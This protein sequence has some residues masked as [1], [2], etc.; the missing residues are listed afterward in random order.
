[1]TEQKKDKA[2]KE[3][4]ADFISGVD[5]SLLNPIGLSYGPL[6]GEDRPW[7]DGD[8]YRRIILTILSYRFIA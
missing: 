5:Q 3:L 6:S 4:N 2:K 7:R 8:G 1:M